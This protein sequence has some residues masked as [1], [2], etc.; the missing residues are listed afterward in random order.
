MLR[1]ALCACA[2]HQMLCYVMLRTAS[3]AAR[4]GVAH[5]YA[6]VCV[7]VHADE[8]LSGHELPWA[9]SRVGT[10]HVAYLNTRPTKTGTGTGTKRRLGF[11]FVAPCWSALPPGAKRPVWSLSPF[12][13][14]YVER[15]HSLLK[16]PPSPRPP[17]AHHIY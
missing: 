10:P 1:N 17:L 16:G 7:I 12:R 9:I 2:G 14:A 11:S 6:C 5:A 4:P 15:G 13:R 3:L 8:G